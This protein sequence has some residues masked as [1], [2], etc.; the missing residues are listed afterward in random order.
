MVAICSWILGAAGKVSALGRGCLLQPPLWVATTED[1][2]ITGETGL[3][4]YNRNVSSHADNT[5]CGD[6]VD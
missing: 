5:S 4:S 3:F 2:S 6:L 1:L